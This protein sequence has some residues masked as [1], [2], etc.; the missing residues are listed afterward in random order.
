MQLNM[1]SLKTFLFFSFILSI[2]GFVHP[3]RS[4][5][6]VDNNIVS[7]LSDSLQISAFATCTDASASQ[8]AENTYFIVVQTITGGNG[9]SYQVSDGTGTQ[10]FSGTP[11]YFGPY[12]HS[13]SGGAFQ[14]ITVDDLVRSFTCIVEAP[15]VLCGINNGNQAAGGFC[16]VENAD[17]ANTGT[18]LAQYQPGTFQSGGTSGQIQRYVLVNSNNVVVETNGTGFFTGL[19]DGTYTPYAINYPTDEMG[20]IS[21]FLNPGVSFQTIVDGF[22]GSGTLSSAC[23]D[24]CNAD[25]LVEYTVNGCRDY[26]D[27][28]DFDN[29]ITYATNESNNG[30]GLGASHLVFDN[31]SIGTGIDTEVDGLANTK[32]TGDDLDNINDEDGITIPTTIITGTTINIEANVLIPSGTSAQLFVWIDWNADGI[33]ASNEASST[34][35]IDG[36]T[37]VLQATTLSVNVPAN[38]NTT[39]LLGARFRLFDVNETQ[40]LATGAAALGGEVEDYLISV[41]PCPHPNCR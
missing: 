34:P 25:G 39:Q 5:S 36:N 10:T 20:T 29:N 35:I 28:P 33:L 38:A 14:T 1:T 32:A 18:I 19:A 6:K 30:E 40:K 15:E 37:G 24:L 7:H 21:P 9:S 12:I 16:D 23:F 8:A 13:G 26:G 17:G 3:D 4:A 31:F 27:L 22:N 41:L 11:I 2:Y